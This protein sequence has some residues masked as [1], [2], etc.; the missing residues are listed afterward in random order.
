MDGHPRCDVTAS[1]QVRLLLLI[2]LGCVDTAS[3]AGPSIP[4]DW[5]KLGNTIAAQATADQPNFDDRR[6]WPF[7]SGR[8]DYVAQD[9]PE[10]TVY[11]WAHPGENGGTGRG[12]KHNPGDPKNWLVD[13]KP[14]RTIAFGAKADICLPDADQHYSVD[15]PTDEFRHV[16]VGRNAHLSASGRGRKV[17]GNLWVKRGGSFGGGGSTE[18]L[19]DRHAFVRVDN[20]PEAMEGGP[21]ARFARKADPASVRLGHYL[22]FDKNNASVEVLGFADCLDEF[23]VYCRLI[24]GPD[25]RLQP[26]RNAT[27]ELGPR[28]QIVLMDGAC[29]GSWINNFVEG[30]PDLI[31]EGSVLGG[32]PER[33]LTRDATWW[34][35]F[36]DFTRA[37]FR[38]PGA[39]EKY[40]EGPSADLRA[41]A[42]VRGYPAAGADA[43]LVVTLNPYS[44][45]AGKLY[46]KQAFPGLDSDGFS[47]TEGSSDR[48]GYVTKAH[49]EWYQKLPRHITL[50]IDQ[51]VEV[52]NVTFDYVAKGGL[53]LV[54]QAAA[55]KWDD[56]RFGPHCAGPLAELIRGA[57]AE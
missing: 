27:P 49:Q 16:T 23:R 15:L 5:P 22:R 41:G 45:W 33:P 1:T 12:A 9:W 47:Y 32:T 57:D 24:V 48:L 55:G 2:L 31:V 19:G 50:R 53:R 26:G 14:A 18:W 21:K 35:C 38:G 40:E 25:S 17:F 20:H 54:D 51:N 42:V 44:I 30:R 8:E 39:W 29:F 3:A 34:L 13:G 11:V 28:G 56:V 37:Q 52:A 46:S 10:T 6:I 4:V 43:R 7:L 36:K